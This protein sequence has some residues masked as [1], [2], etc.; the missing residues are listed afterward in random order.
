[1]LSA[2]RPTVKPDC[3]ASRAVMSGFFST[4]SEMLLVM[5][6]ERSIMAPE[7]P[8]KILAMK[9]RVRLSCE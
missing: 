6:T 3:I 1:M 5:S 4:T 8:M 7:E 2:A 9:I